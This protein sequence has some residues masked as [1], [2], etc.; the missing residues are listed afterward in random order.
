[1]LQSVVAVRSDA[2]DCSRGEELCC[3][4]LLV[5]EVVSQTILGA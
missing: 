2:T 1:M 4:V 5:L 3:R